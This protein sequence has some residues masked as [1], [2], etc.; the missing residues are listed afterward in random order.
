MEM[1]L[2]LKLI[3]VL[4]VLMVVPT[5]AQ[6]VGIVDLGNEADRYKYVV[7]RGD[8]LWDLA[9]TFLDNPFD[10]PMIWQ[11]NPQIEDPHWI[12][13]G[14]VLM[15]VPEAVLRQRKI[16][17]LPR[18]NIH[19]AEAAGPAG[20]ETIYIAGETQV[21]FSPSKVIGF[22]TETEVKDNVGAIIGSPV[23]RLNFGEP[24]L[25]YIDV[26]ESSGIKVGDKF[27]IFRPIKSVKHPVRGKKVG[28]Q[29]LTL[30][31]MEVLVVYPSMST[32]KITYSNEDII[33]GDRLTPTLDFPITVQFRDAPEQYRD[34]P[35]ESY[36]IISRRNLPAIGKD[37]IV[38]ID[39]GKKAGIEPGMLFSVYLTGKKLEGSVQG[40]DE[41]IG[42]MVVL[43]AGDDYSTCLVT[44]SA[45]EFKPGEHI[46]TRRFP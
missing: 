4:T 37:E 44:K 16:D 43:M 34:Q 40:P 25:V 41:I 33:K 26:G 3:L 32:A 36:I 19:G 7:K 35:L 15:I 24:D 20:P 9:A 1:R 39:A 22:M 42:E 11:Q 17:S 27:T 14:D 18:T 31:D 38:Y 45:K 46:R 28:Q 12:Y 13:P 23:G 29:I 2:R 10:W 5:V 8:T 21:T 6:Q 30:G